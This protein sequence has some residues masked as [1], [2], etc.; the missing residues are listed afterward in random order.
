MTEAAVVGVDRVPESWVFALSDV[1][2][3]LAYHDDS[4]SV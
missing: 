4:T 1:D 2:E 3:N